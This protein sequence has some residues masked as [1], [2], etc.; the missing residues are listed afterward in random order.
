MRQGRL[1][2]KIYCLA[3]VAKPKLPAGF[4]ADIEFCYTALKIFGDALNI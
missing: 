3:D 4:A 2:Q 1:Q